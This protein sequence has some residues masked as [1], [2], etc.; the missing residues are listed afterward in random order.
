MPSNPEPVFAST[1]SFALTLDLGVLL[2]RPEPFLWRLRLVDTSLYPLIICIWWLDRLRLLALYTS[3]FVVITPSLLYWPD[4]FSVLPTFETGHCNE[5]HSGPRLDTNC[6]LCGVTLK[7]ARSAVGADL[8]LEPIP[9]AGPCGHAPQCIH[10]RTSRGISIVSRSS[11]MIFPRV[12]LLQAPAEYKRPTSGAARDLADAMAP[13]LGSRLPSALVSQPGMDVNEDDHSL[14]SPG[15]PLSMPLVSAGPR[16]EALFRPTTGADTDAVA[17]AIQNAA[18]LHADTGL[19]NTPSLGVAYPT[20]GVERGRISTSSFPVSPATRYTLDPLAESGMLALTARGTGASPQSRSTL[21]PNPPLARDVGLVPV[22]TFTTG[23]GFPDGGAPTAYPFVSTNVDA[24]LLKGSEP[25]GISVTTALAAAAP[26]VA[27]AVALV[28]PLHGYT[29]ADGTPSTVLPLD[30]VSTVP[31][32]AGPSPGDHTSSIMPGVASSA[33][34]QRVVAQP[35]AT[36]LG[37]SEMYMIC[38]AFPYGAAASASVQGDLFVLPAD[39][40]FCL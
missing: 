14:S 24:S 26:N 18:S 7:R 13:P 10:T 16:D 34:N 30:N 4:R 17:T 6:L 20:E 39:L 37:P 36:H 25:C 1:R 33:S 5:H 3:H 40:A 27:Q 9:T 32:T 12:P 23:V 2:S 28:T 21:D 22:D 38:D 31:S 15:V 11:E 19:A 8:H 29:T 35:A